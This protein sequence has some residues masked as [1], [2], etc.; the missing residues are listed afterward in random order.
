MRIV[1]LGD[2]NLD[3]LARLR[4]DLAPGDEARDRITVEPGGSAGTFAR[5]AA[6]AGLE[7]T[8]IGAVGRDLVGDLLERSLTDA[9]VT[10]EL[11]RMDMPSGAVLAIERDGERS[12]VCSRSA[13]DGLSPEWVHASWPAS[14][15][16]VHV[17][18][19]A[20]LS[21]PQRPAVLCALDLAREVAASVSIDPPPASLIRAFGVHTFARLLPDGAW[22]F[23]NLSEARLLADATEPDV[24]AGRLRRRFPVGAVTLGPD[25]ALAWDTRGQHRCTT[26]PLHSVNTTGAGDVYAATFVV[27][28][29]ETG[30]LKQANA[31][32]CTAARAMLQS[33][34]QSA[35][36]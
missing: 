17:S 3:I 29:L 6:S 23:P 18:G 9:G 15:A 33:R 13:N 24:V 5:T 26:D 10:C 25:G 1:V 12:M 21:D 28:Y 31:T 22:L 34:R 11:R 30:N 4:G 36:A 7:V 27:H 16:H 2:L 14:P 35:I 8:F 32:A 20:L 19:Y